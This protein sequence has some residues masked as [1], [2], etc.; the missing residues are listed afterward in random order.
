LPAGFQLVAD[1]LA[2]M[3]FM[4][5]IIATFGTA[6]LAANSFAFTY[7]HVSFMP[8]IGVG[9]AVTALVGKYIGMGRH[10]LAERRAHLGFFVC[11]AYMVTCGIV[12][13]A[14]RHDLIGVFS[15]DIDVLRI[16]AVLMVFLAL[17]QIFDAMFIAYVGALRGAGD[18]LVPAAVQ[19]ALVWTIVVGGGAVAVR[20]APQYGVIGPWTLAT[21]FGAILGIYLL[22]RFRRGRWRSIRLHEDA[23]DSQTNVLPATLPM[24]VQLGDPKP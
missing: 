7:M 21:V 24:S 11:A 9:A 19:G 15:K 23:A 18:T 20:Y 10:D 3:V 1:V 16:G 14:F 13:F 5:I 22:A 17:Y 8:A 12:F 4:N 6:A 2:W